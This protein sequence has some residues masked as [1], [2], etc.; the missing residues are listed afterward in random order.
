MLVHDRRLRSRSAPRARRRLGCD[1]EGLET[2]RLLAATPINVASGL[3]LASGLPLPGLATGLGLASGVATLPSSAVSVAPASVA[4][5]AVAANPTIISMATGPATTLSPL[6]SDA[7]TANAAAS[8]VARPIPG[9][10]DRISVILPAPEIVAILHLQPNEPR[11]VEPGPE[12]EPAIPAPATP[13]VPA[14]VSN[15]AP[16]AAAAPDDAPRPVE[17]PVAFEVRD[18]T[19]ELLATEPTD[20]LAES[21]T[22]FAV[23]TQGPLAAGALLAAWGGWKYGSRLDGRSRRRPLVINP[24]SNRDDDPAHP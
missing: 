21:P 16:P 7:E 17:P 10:S 4:T 12:L 11:T 14:P 20:L 2:R 18:A 5:S 23:T 8:E 19:L 22:E 1:P 9:R 15:P 3:V 24:P 6:M 13:T